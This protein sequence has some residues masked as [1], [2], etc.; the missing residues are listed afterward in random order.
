[1]FV[2]DWGDDALVTW[3][4]TAGGA[5]PTRR[6][7]YAPT[8]YVGDPAGAL[9]GPGD[10]PARTGLSDELASL[11]ASLSTDRRVVD[12][13]VV[14]Q[15][16]TWRTD[17]RPVLAVTVADVAAVRPLARRVHERGRPG[18][19]TCYDVDL[20][21]G[22]RYC[23][24]TG[25]DPTPGRPPRTL[26]VGVDCAGSAAAVVPAVDDR[27]GNGDGATVTVTTVGVGDDGGGDGAVQ[28]SD[29]S[30]VTDVLCRLT[31]AG[32]RLVDD[33][34]HEDGRDDR[35]AGAR[36]DAR[37]ALAALSDRIATVDPDVLVVDTARLVPLVCE[38]A[39]ALGVDLQVG[40]RPGYR[41][42]AGASTYTSYGRVGRSPARYG[43]PGRAVVDR[44]NTFFFAETNLAGCL[45]LVARSGKP[46]QELSWASIGNVLT[47]IQIRTA[48]D[49]GVLVPWRPW[50]PERSTPAG[51]L[52]EA[53]R[54]GVTLAP[55]VGVHEDVHE[56]DFAS[57]YPNVIVTRNLSPETVR[58]DCCATDDVPG[59][60][61]SVC[62][63]PGYLPDVLGPLVS[64]RADLK[65]E[66][67]ERRSRDASGRTGEEGSASGAPADGPGDPGDPCD[68]D[69]TTDRRDALDGQI[70]ALKWIL[71]SCFGYQGF[72]NA[73]FGR[74]ECHEAINAYAREIL[75]DAKTRLEAG[76]WRVLHGV[77]DSLWVTARPDC[78]QTSLSELAATVSAD[79]GIDLEYETTYDWFAVCPLRD[80]DAGA[81][82]RY[83]GRERDGGYTY[84]GIEC[85]QR[86]TCPFVAAVQ[87][88]LIERFDATRA[89]EAVCARLAAA[90]RRLRAGELDPRRLVERARVSQ[91][92]DAYDHYTR[93]AAA[94]D[95]AGTLERDHPPGTDVRFVVVDDDATTADRVA[96]ASELPDRDASR[97][98][99][100]YYRRELHR[101]AAS[102]LGPLGWTV[103]DVRAALADGTAT[104]LD[105]Y[106]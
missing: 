62:D 1:V 36:S 104:T 9:Y 73:K 44:S 63:A 26:S 50:R 78:E 74:I 80:G 70:S 98:D 21:P 101:A 60:G 16:Q 76:G 92:V 30:T 58:C 23:L 15:R 46:L 3:R 52:D 59:L 69:A 53:D 49:R 94:L 4:L 72:S 51:T 77:V 103:A 39:T 45:D 97:Y 27:S 84:R 75:L 47:G 68:S 12:T 90:I 11:R 14:E 86:S 71:V 32:D 96:L 20:A 67:R 105:A 13:D 106:G 18:Q 55:A 88:A 81:L 7:D 87:R 22:F 82:T 83:F 25:T 2:A 8:F 99:V 54:G 37:A 79:A 5:T 48:R 35:G 91:P 40:R 93:T 43:V 85:R 102:V 89:P 65:A 34:G 24:E 95:R 19:F 28:S 29:R 33:A 61:Y 56:L 6:S 64:D 38:A 57:L 41:K 31:C 42:R 66:R 100:D 10:P 17:P